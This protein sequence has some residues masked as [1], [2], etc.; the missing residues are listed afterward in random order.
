MA[1]HFRATPHIEIG[2]EL[3]YFCA[4]R[5]ALQRDAIKPELMLSAGGWTILDVEE[6]NGQGISFAQSGRGWPRPIFRSR[7]G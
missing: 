1:L 2:M 3:M 5:M 7:C 4:D 6:E